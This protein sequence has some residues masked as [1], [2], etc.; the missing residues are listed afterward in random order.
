MPFAAA[1]SFPPFWKC[2]KLCWPLITLMSLHPK[3][4]LMFQISLGHPCFEV[5]CKAACVSADRVFR[6]NMCKSESADSALNPP[7]KAPA[8]LWT[9]LLTQAFMRSSIPVQPCTLRLIM[10][11]TAREVEGAFTVRACQSKEQ[12]IGEKGRIIRNLV[13]FLLPLSLLSVSPCF[14]CMFQKVSPITEAVPPTASPSA[15]RGGKKEGVWGDEKMERFTEQC[16]FELM[17]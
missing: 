17:V 3:M 7:I 14:I 2:T 16:E 8:F 15:T 13:R 6:C 9:P 11:R 1:F 10:P 12:G 4:Y 5:S